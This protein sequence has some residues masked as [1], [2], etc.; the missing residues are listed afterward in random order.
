L[1]KDTG[2][3]QATEAELD[4]ATTKATQAALDS[5]T[6]AEHG[7]LVMAQ[8]QKVTA[9]IA[10]SATQAR[11]LAS[12]A[13]TLSGFYSSSAYASSKARAEAE[14]AKL[15]GEL[16]AA[17]ASLAEVNQ[18]LTPPKPV[19]PTP[20][21]SKGKE[22]QKPTKLGNC[23]IRKVDFA[24]REYPDSIGF[25]ASNVVKVVAGAGP[26]GIPEA[27]P[28]VRIGRVLYGDLNSNGTPEAYVPLEWNGGG[29]LGSSSIAVEVY[30]VDSQCSL[31]SLGNIV[32]SAPHAEAKIVGQSYV[33]QA[34]LFGESGPE[35]EHAFGP[36]ATSKQSYGFTGGKLTLTKYEETPY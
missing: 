4:R 29:P 18:R 8:V 12:S 2:S 22:T 36:V 7:R 9:A 11:Q 28:S 30:E 17:K 5:K 26:A 3:L 32:Y 19:K 20:S 21:G 27:F 13:R 6:S 10:T 1:K 15:E 14:A 33:I 35:T 16:S 23:D 31:A 34:V 24:N 25:G